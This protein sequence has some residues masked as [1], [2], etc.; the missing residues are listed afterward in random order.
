VHSTLTLR[1]NRSAKR[2]RP[3]RPRRSPDHVDTFGGEHRVERPGVHGVPVPDE[4]PARSTSVAEV[5]RQVAGLLGGPGGG[6]VGG[7]AEDVDAAGSDLHD[8]Q[9]VQT[10]QRHRV[11]V[12]EVCR[13][14][15]RCLRPQERTPARI[16]LAWR[17]ADP[18]G[19]E[20]ATDRAG[21]DPMAGPDQFALDAPAACAVP[22]SV[23]RCVSCG[24]VGNSDDLAVV[25]RM[26][27]LA[28]VQVFGWLALLA[29]GDA[30][31]TAELLV[32]ASRGSGS[33]SSDRQTSPVMAGSSGVV[34]ADP[35]P[36]PVGA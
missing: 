21:A 12:E 28:M 33:T 8:E 35:A 31:K 15:P 13:E 29:R 9:H 32:L 26:L 17:R 1:T 10:A 5:R 6:R 25:I 11:D 24:V 36:A 34:R 7:N 20:D 16:D 3:R 19:G 30:A 4:E 23:A 2:V 18:T 14:Q 22:E 27:Y